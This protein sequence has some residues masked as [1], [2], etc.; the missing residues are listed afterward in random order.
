MLPGL[1]GGR[2]SWGTRD[3]RVHTHTQLLPYLSSKQNTLSSDLC[4]HFHILCHVLCASMTVSIFNVDYHVPG[5][6]KDMVRHEAYKAWK[7]LSNQFLYLQL[8]YIYFS[9]KTDL[10]W[11]DNSSLYFLFL[12]PF[13]VT[14]WKRGLFLYKRHAFTHSL[15]HS[16]TL[17]QG[18]ETSK[19]QDTKII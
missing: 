19:Y 16:G 14:L 18:A 4:H 5:Y 15:A 6:T 9:P 11:G 7:I 1:P 2:R 13:P 12:C 17:P 8:Q 3:M 10:S